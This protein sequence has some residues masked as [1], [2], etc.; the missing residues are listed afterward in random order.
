MVDTTV[1]TLW[2]RREENYPAIAER[3]GGM[4]REVPGNCLALFPSYDF[5][6]QIAGRMPRLEHQ[7]LVQRQTDDGEAREAL[8]E[9]LRGD[10]VLATCCCC[11][12][13]AASS[14]RASTT[15][16]TCCRR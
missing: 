13:P 4:V 15:P 14:P 11:R 2:R 6:E 3:L 16:A 7:L 1:T 5:L 9:R 10:A 12:W 8:L